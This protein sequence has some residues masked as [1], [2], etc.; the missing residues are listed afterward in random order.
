MQADIIVGLQFGD[1]GKGKVSLC[2]S[3][4]TELNYDVCLR[5]NGGPNAGHTV[6]HN[7]Q[8]IILHQIPCGIINNK[9]SVIGS[10]CVVDLGKL[11]H[12]I[13][14]L[15]EIGIPVENLLKIAYNT[16]V[17]YTKHLNED[18]SHD[19]AGSTG[20][21]IRPVNRDKYDRCGKRICDL[22]SNYLQGLIGDVKII[23]PVYLLN[24]KD[25]RVLCEGA[26]GFELDIDYGCYPFV[27]S[28]HCCSGFVFNS[29][30]SPKSVNK[31]YGAAK[32]YNTYVGN[33]KFQPDDD[34]L[35]KLAIIGEEFGSTTGRARQ[36][37]WMDL[38][39]LKKAITVNG[40]TDLIINKCD[41]L[42]SLNVFKLI[43]N[44]QIKEFNKWE[45]FQTY[46]NQSLSEFLDSKSIIYSENKDRI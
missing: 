10:G 31:V 28:T 40:V 38:D 4:D 41:I 1:E 29:G 24:K 12:E 7:G 20:S 37:N 35:K 19:V 15:K 36:C 33:M 45:E 14:A 3:K 39:R 17:I 25:T 9:V 16:H 13:N 18:K 23:D 27:T 2:L 8:K 6:Y 46:I 22:D 26:Q 5:F 21:G 30:I 32:I 11:M 42:K 44:N 34:D 43:E